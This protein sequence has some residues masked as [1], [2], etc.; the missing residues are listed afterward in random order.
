LINVLRG[1]L[2]L[3]GP[4][5]ITAEEL[6]RYG[7]RARDL[8]QVRPGLTGHWQ[9]SGRSQVSYPER[10]RLDLSY[11]SGWSLRGDVAIL[12]KTVARLW[13]AQQDAV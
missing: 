4:R 2:S 11:V 12:A 5:P 13:S 1:E 7:D 3:V 10:V 8:L 9:V 6:P